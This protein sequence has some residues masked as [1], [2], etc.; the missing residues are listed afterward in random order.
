MVRSIY[1]NLL[2]PQRTLM[3]F[4]DYEARGEACHLIQLMGDNGV[5]DDW[6][7]LLVCRHNLAVQL[8]IEGKY[9]VI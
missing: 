9:N 8:V 7:S 6:C 3:Y 5:A 2:F 1:K 4:G